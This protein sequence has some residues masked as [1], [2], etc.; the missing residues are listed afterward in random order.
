MVGIVSCCLPSCSVLRDCAQT[1][2]ND[3]KTTRNCFFFVAKCL[4]RVMCA[5]I[6][7]LCCSWRLY[8]RK[9]ETIFRRL[10]ETHY[11][12]RLRRLMMFAFRRRRFTNCLTYLLKVPS[13]SL[14]L[15]AKASLCAVSLSDPDDIRSSELLVCLRSNIEARLRLD[16]KEFFGKFP[17]LK[18]C[19]DAA[20]AAGQITEHSSTGQ[21]TCDTAS[22]R[23]HSPPLSRWWY[24][25]FYKC[26]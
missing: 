4:S 19:C 20:R 13:K 25:T 10:S 8:S 23:Y 21:M 14:A 6:T 24:A 16:W 15:S 5:D 26:I 17:S 7:T 22:A 3:T 1:A 9:S 18:Q 2:A 11:G 12:S